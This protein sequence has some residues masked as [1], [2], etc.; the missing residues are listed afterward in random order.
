MYVLERRSGQDRSHTWK[1]YVYCGNSQIL[2]LVRS[3][4]DAS[5][6]WRIRQIPLTC[7]QLLHKGY[8]HTAGT[9]YRKVG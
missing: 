8:F 1:P 7:D 2:R 5:A 9:F 4:F 6:H 3:G